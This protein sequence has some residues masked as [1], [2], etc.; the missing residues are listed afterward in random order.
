MTATVPAARVKKT[1]RVMRGVVTLSP[2]DGLAVVRFAVAEGKREDGY[3]AIHWQDSHTVKVCHRDDPARQYTVT[4]SASTGKPLGCSCPG[5]G[6]RGVGCRHQ[7]SVAK[8][9]ELGLLTFPVLE[10]AGHDRAATE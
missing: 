9:T 5:F 1:A 6:F 8:L 2:F 4:C 7:A 3:T 10:D